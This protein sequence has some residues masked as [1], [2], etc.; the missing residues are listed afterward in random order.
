M[1]K[2]LISHP[3]TGVETGF[4]HNGI[5]AH[6]R[7]YATHHNS[8]CES[9]EICR[10]DHLS[11]TSGWDGHKPLPTRPGVTMTTPPSEWVDTTNPEYDTNHEWGDFY[12]PQ[13]ENNNEIDP[14]IE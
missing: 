8:W 1:M 4:A 9:D 10:D 14:K 2:M 12:Y 13:K 11:I 7:P 3:T 6:C 5:T